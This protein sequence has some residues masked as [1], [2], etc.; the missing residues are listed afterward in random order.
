MLVLDAQQGVPLSNAPLR[1]PRA[2]NLEFIVWPDVT[3]RALRVDPR[4]RQRPL[5]SG[6][7]LPFGYW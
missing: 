5:T 7:R 4:L 3:Y 2:R 1:G 6:G